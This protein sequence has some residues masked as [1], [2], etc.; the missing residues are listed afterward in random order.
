MNEFIRFSRIFEICKN[1]EFNTTR[2][3]LLLVII[4]KRDLLVIRD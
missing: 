4:L 2:F 1:F 3:N